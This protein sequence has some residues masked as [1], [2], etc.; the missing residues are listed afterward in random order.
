M[1]KVEVTLNN[2]LFNSGILGFYRIIENTKK[3]NLIDIKRKCITNS[4]K[5]F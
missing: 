4:T 3:E 2:F 1:D 5:S